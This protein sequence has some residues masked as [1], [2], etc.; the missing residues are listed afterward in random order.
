MYGDR[1]GSPRR[2]DRQSFDPAEP[3]RAAAPSPT[4]D[5]A[6]HPSEAP[7]VSQA[8]PAA[9]DTL[10]APVAPHEDDV[11]VA[12]ER[13][14][15]GGPTPGGTFG[16]E[17]EPLGAAGAD[18]RDEITS[19][20]PAPRRAG[21]SGQGGGAG[22]RNGVRIAAIA[23]GAAVVLGAATAG[24]LALT[25]G[26]S[27][28]GT[29][30]VKPTKQLADAAAPKVDPKVL[31]EQR[32]QLALERASRETREDGGKGPSLLPKGEPLPT[33]TPKPGGGDGG[34]GG[35]G[36]TG[37]PVPAGE[38]QRIA[39]GLLP[40]YGFGGSGQFGCLVNLWNRES[41]WNTHA[42][43]PSGAYGIPQALPGSKMASAGPDWQNNATTQI[44]WGLG[45]I[46]SRYKT[47]CG[48]WSHFQSAGWY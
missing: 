47:P 18:D 1:P 43:N 5:Q 33:K 45:Y 44:K 31:E 10:A 21:R 13:P 8:Q 40:G 23:A 19:R 12:G 4:S 17:A 37:D 6:R 38:A 14:R 22:R 39:K 26:G 9:Q 34:G 7:L 36:P 35:G 24:A 2:D 48:G 15:T 41:G 20:G 42:A 32:R 16:F 3:W 27:D 46:K 25:G 30:T 11:K 29:Q 28:D